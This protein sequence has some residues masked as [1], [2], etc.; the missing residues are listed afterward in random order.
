MKTFKEWWKEHEM[1]YLHREHKDLMMEESWDAC[2]EEYKNH[3]KTVIGD[4][5]KVIERLQ[6]ELGQL[7]TTINR[8][9]K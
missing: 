2:A 8:I 6:L 7:H 1:E 4:Y 5:R 3:Y 9:I